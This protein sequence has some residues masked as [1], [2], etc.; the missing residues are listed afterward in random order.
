VVVRSKAK[1]AREKDIS[2]NARNKENS[3][4]LRQGQLEQI[5]GAK[6]EA[7]QVP[8]R[9]MELLAWKL[10]DKEKRAAKKQRKA[11]EKIQAANRANSERFMQGFLGNQRIELG[12]HQKVMADPGG[13]FCVQLTQGPWISGKEL[14]EVAS[15]FN[16]SLDYH[17]IT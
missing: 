1:R 14:Y 13:G 17:Y 7:V 11:L 16:F 8:S 3:K 5:T 2:L 9:Q 4:R 10:K 12:L 6:V 15:G